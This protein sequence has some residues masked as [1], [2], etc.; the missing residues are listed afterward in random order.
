[1]KIRARLAYVVILE[2]DVPD[3]L[4]AFVANPQILLDQAKGALTPMFE[5]GIRALV[6]KLALV[7][8][9]VKAEAG[10]LTLQAEPPP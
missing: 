2:A 1:M 7:G 6:A 9:R 3:A 4:R 10:D 8:V 5:G